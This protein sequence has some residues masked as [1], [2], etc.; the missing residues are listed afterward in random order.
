MDVAFVADLARKVGRVA[1]HVLYERVRTPVLRTAADVPRTP[2]D[3]NEQW[4]TAVLCA[5]RGV[6]GL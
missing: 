5:Q 4:L 1:G 2:D 6:S 3:F